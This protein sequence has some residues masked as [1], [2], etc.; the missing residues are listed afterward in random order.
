[1]SV[2]KIKAHDRKPSLEAVLSFAGTTTVPALADSVVSF[3]MR[4]KG[5]A[6]PDF[7][8][9]AKVNAAAVVVD[10]ATATVRYDWAVADTAEP[11]DFLAEFEVVGPDGLTQTFP[12]DSYLDVRIYADLDD[13]P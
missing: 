2:H 13:A 5:G 1:V 6:G 4:K 12:T 9:P 8:V 10:P 3:I 11:G 7:T